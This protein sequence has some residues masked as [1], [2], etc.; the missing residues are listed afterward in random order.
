MIRQMRKA[1]YSILAIFLILGFVGYAF[2]GNDV[3]LVGTV[4]ADNTVTDDSGAVYQIGENDKTDEISEHAG[5]KVEIMGTVE[6]GTDG[7]KTIMINSYKLV[8]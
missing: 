3:K 1:R 4:S 5:K 8:E 6:E 2:A 7:S